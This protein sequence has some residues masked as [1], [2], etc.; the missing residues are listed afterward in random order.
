MGKISQELIRLY[1][2]LANDR[3]PWIQGPK[4]QSYSQGLPTKEEGIWAQNLVT[5]TPVCYNF[6]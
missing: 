2:E 5:P 4:S 6:R 1:G 3:A